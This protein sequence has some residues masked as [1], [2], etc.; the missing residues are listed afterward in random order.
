MNR[1]LRAVLDEA[2]R[3]V[4]VVA[5]FTLVLVAIYHVYAG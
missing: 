5:L 4:F 3:A 2:V 1:R